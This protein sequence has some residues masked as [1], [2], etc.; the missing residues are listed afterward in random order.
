MS[1]MT[2]KLS[3]MLEDEVFRQAY[4]GNE[5]IRNAFD[6]LAG[7]II[8]SSH[9][10]PVDYI[11][12]VFG[13]AEDASREADQLEQDMQQRSDLNAPSSDT[14]TLRAEHVEALAEVLNFLY[15][16]SRGVVEQSADCD[17][18]VADINLLLGVV[19]VPVKTRSEEYAYG[20]YVVRRYSGREV[21]YGTPG[22]MADL[23]EITTDA[24]PVFV[25]DPLTSI[26]RRLDGE[27]DLWREHLSRL[28]TL[29]T[30]PHP[31]V[32]RERVTASETVGMGDGIP[33]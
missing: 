25:A 12:R 6:T 7:S 16:E 14:V 5:R 19:P 3:A 11:E 18:I 27:V 2:N 15:D 33:F 4:D 9:T 26:P 22:A 20:A 8:Q 30:F 1:D 23:H 28:E 21:K 17:A 32:P 29:P 10:D 24:G 13:E 31:I